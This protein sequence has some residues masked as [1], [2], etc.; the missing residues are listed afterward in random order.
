MKMLPPLIK[1]ESR[2]SVY[3][4]DSM[5]FADQPKF[6]NMVVRAKTELSPEALLHHV[7]NVERRMGRD[8]KT[9]NR[10]RV[11]DL[12]ILFYD[13]ETVDTPDLTIP[14]PRIAE[15]AFVLVPMCDIAPRFVH[16]A[17]KVTITDLLKRLPDR[18]THAERTNIRV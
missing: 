15:R 9:H 17:L 4:T 7:Q 10:P 12:D 2:S 8:S 16:P 14:H 3:E 13:D 11:I 18:K 1:V 6:Y 5:Y